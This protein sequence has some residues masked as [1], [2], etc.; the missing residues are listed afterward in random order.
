VAPP[1]NQLVKAENKSM[2]EVI[3]NEKVI[4]NDNSDNGGG[5]FNRNFYYDEVFHSRGDC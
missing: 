3:A 4:R 2:E 1:E 5:Y